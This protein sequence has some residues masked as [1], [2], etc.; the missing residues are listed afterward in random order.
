MFEFP[1]DREKKKICYVLVF[2]MNLL[3]NFLFC[4]ALFSLFLFVYLSIYSADLPSTFIDVERQ[5]RVR[6]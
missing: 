2:H 6:R 1:F 4:F 3:F 5:E